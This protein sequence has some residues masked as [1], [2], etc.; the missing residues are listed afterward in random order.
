MKQSLLLLLAGFESS[1]GLTEQFRNFFNVFKREISKELRS[2][3]AT[4]IKMSRGHFS[5]SGFFMSATGQTDYFSLSDVRD[6]QYGLKHNPNS[7]MSQ[8]L[9]RTA[10]D[11]KDYTGGGNQYVAIKSGMANEMRL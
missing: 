10:K 11:Y 2:V 7:C 8:L 5:V 1:S 4:N 6:M 9:Y 3:G